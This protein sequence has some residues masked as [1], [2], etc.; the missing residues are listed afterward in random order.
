MTKTP[1]ESVKLL[2]PVDHIVLGFAE[3]AA[4]RDATAA[5]AQA[6][7]DGPAVREYTAVEMHTALNAE[8]EAAGPL[9][10]LGQDTNLAEFRR[11]LAA[12]GH[13]WLVVHAPDDEQTAQVTDIARRF[14]ARLAQKFTRFTIEDLV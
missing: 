12:D 2:K 6:G 7:F 14:G 9:A 4:L 8:L 3:E 1:P 11:K 10:S 13:G 5:L